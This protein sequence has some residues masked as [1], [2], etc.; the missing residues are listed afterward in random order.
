VKDLAAVLP[1]ES[2]KAASRENVGRLDTILLAAEMWIRELEERIK[3]LAE[4]GRLDGKTVRALQWE[5]EEIK[6]EA[7]ERRKRVQKLNKWVE[8]LG[9][10]GEAN[11]KLMSWVETLDGEKGGLVGNIEHLDREM[12]EGKEENGALRKEVRGRRNEERIEGLVEEV[13]RLTEANEGLKFE[14]NGELTEEGVEQWVAVLQMEAEEGAVERD[15]LR[16]EVE[17][18]VMENGRLKKEAASKDNKG[19]VDGEEERAALMEDSQAMR[20]ELRGMM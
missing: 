13:Q 7:V 9:G 5:V 10:G 8:L 1:A 15:V 17:R 4:R 3:D 2:L 14:L 12:K 6:R 20:E 19:D 11:H 18:L 16:A